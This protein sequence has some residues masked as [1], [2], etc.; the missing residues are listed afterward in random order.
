MC[1]RTYREG[2]KEK[3]QSY[4]KDK[5]GISKGILLTNVQ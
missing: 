3:E 1:R 2:A 4:E 5:E